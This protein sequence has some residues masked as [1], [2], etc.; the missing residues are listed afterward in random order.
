MKSETNIHLPNSRC[1]LGLVAS[2]SPDNITMVTLVACNW[3]GIKHISDP[4]G[5]SNAM[6]SYESDSWGFWPKKGIS[7][8]C[9]R[10]QPP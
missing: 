7:S 9:D 4:M 8:A 5:K 3:E 2:N 6:I 1:T 10:G